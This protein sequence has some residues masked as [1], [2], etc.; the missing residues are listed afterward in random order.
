MGK[1]QAL[2]KLE[3]VFIQQDA[4]YR[5]ANGWL[6]TPEQLAIPKWLALRI[7]EGYAHPPPYRAESLQELANL[8]P[9]NGDEKAITTDYIHK[10]NA[11]KVL[12]DYFVQRDMG[13][14]RG[15]VPKWTAR[16]IVDGAADLSVGAPRWE[17]DNL[18][19]LAEAIA[20]S[21]GKEQ[22]DD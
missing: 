22:A 19:T 20:A 13:W 4:A 7:T 9:D 16:R 6:Y 21:A 14:R 17:A 5:R 12:E 8:L 18:V 3:H 15:G 10:A 2:D 11:I 1:A